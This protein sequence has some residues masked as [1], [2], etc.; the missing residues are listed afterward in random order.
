MTLQD[1]VAGLAMTALIAGA[2]AQS[3][4]SA[5]LGAPPGQFVLP[6]PPPPCPPVPAAAGFVSISDGTA[7]T[8]DDIQKFNVEWMNP[9]WCAYELTQAQK[10]FSYRQAGWAD[11]ERMRA[12]TRLYELTQDVRYLNHLWQFIQLILLYRDDH[13]PGNPDPACKRCEPTPIDD[14]RGGH[15]AGWGGVL[16]GNLSGI[17]EDLTGVLTYPIATFARIVA[18]DPSLQADYGPDAV[19]YANSA[20]ET[21]WALMP[22]MKFQSVGNLFEG[23]LASPDSYR[24][25]LTQ[26]VCQG[27]EECDNLHDYA[28]SPLEYNGNGAFM[29]TLIELWRALDSP[30]YRSSAPQTNQVEL[31]RNLIPL[32]VSRFQR[33][34]TDHLQ[35]RTDNVNGAPRFFGTIWTAA[36]APTPRTS[37]MAQSICNTS[38]S[39]AA[40]SI[41]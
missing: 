26:Q 18:E 24:T 1:F 16:F 23:Y 21:M 4:H 30:F 12:M 19:R 25:K 5:G 36:Q 41:G 37:R 32:L 38:T 35:T 34:F 28:G 20:V 6:P 40:I 9:D 29:M 13:Y 3:A 11:A 22:Q 10:D 17:S 14:F 27:N 2:A 31:T 39:C 33:F 15:V 8:A 7:I